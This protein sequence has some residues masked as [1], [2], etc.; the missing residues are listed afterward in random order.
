MEIYDDEKKF[1]R[2]AAD[3]NDD[4][5]DGNDDDFSCFCL[6]YWTDNIYRLRDIS[7]VMNFNE[8]RLF[9]TCLGGSSMSES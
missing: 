6:R 7:V 5:D 8:V 2:R 1:Y 4:R 9:T 3:R